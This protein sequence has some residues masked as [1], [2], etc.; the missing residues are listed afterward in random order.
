[1]DA[2]TLLRGTRVLIWLAAAGAACAAPNP[3]PTRLILD[4]ATFGNSYALFRAIADRVAVEVDRLIPGQ[5]MPGQTPADP[6]GGIFCYIAGDAPVTLLGAGQND[7]HHNPS[8]A[9]STRVLP[10]NY[11]EFVF[12]LRMSW[13]TSK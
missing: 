9:L 8:I 4:R 3:S 13:P 5:V 12:E 7:A 1:M 6:S 11:A 10:A 2:V